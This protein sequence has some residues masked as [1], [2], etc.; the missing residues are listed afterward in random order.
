MQPLLYDWNRKPST[1]IKSRLVFDIETDGFLEVLTKI[2]CICIK[3]FDTGSVGKYAP[4]GFPL[5]GVI[6]TIEEGISKLE[7]A[8]QLIGHNIISFD[9]QAIRKVYPKFS[10]KGEIRDTLVYSRVI[11]SDI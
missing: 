7:L 10:P 2:H 11:W 1:E 8:D 9:L 4:A 6:G 3:D 5:R